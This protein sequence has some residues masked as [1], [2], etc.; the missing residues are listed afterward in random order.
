MAATR[1]AAMT[2]LTASQR[3]SEL[4]LLFCCSQPAAL[5]FQRIADWHLDHQFI[6]RPLLQAEQVLKYATR[7]LTLRRAALEKAQV[8]CWTG[9]EGEILGGEGRAAAGGRSGGGV[10]PKRRAAPRAHDASLSQS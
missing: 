9:R 4:L 8:R 6:R 5:S 1:A 3:C 2:R 10:A 7:A